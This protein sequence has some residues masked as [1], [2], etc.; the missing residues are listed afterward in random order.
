MNATL[1]G[2]ARMKNPASLG[3]S[4]LPFFTAIKDKH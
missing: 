1:K 3:L 4:F 2:K